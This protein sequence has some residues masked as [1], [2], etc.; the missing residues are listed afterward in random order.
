[1]LTCGKAKYV[2]HTN[3]FKRRLK[4]HKQD[5]E[6]NKHS[7]DRLRKEYRKGNKL[8]Y[9][10]LARFKTMFRKQV[11]LKEARYIKRYANSNEG[12]PIKSISYTKEEFFMDIADFIRN[13]WKLLVC[14]IFIILVVG[15]G[16]SMEQAYAI[17]QQLINFYQSL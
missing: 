12:I 8:S 17:I 5:L 1:M 2:G 3:N 11:L 15:Y 13:Y 14:V 9:K 7:N 4:Q 16:M 10:I 6:K